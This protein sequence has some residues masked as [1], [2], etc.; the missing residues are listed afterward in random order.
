MSAINPKQNMYFGFGI[1][2]FV[3]SVLRNSPAIA[4]S[5]GFGRL[6]ESLIQYTC[7]LIHT[8]ATSLLLFHFTQH[9]SFA[10]ACG[11]CSRQSILQE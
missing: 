2:H 9:N 10:R 4:T 3:F 6:N 1:L 8:K 11:K 5:L 7:L